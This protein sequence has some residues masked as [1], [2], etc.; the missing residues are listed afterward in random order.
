M[1]SR[2][3][4]LI[5]SLFPSASLASDLDVRSR[6]MV[7][8]GPYQAEILQVIDGDTV[9]ARV[10]IWPG[11]IAEY[12]VRV[13]GVDAPEISRPNCEAELEWGL[14]AKDQVERFYPVGKAIRLRNVQFDVWS[15]RVLADVERFRS[16]RYLSLKD[17]LLQRQ[18]AVEWVPSQGAVPWCLL[19]QAESQDDIEGQ[20]ISD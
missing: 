4:L 20:P 12:S 17:E 8:E 1:L 6:G 14:R 2:C 19:A 3:V 18:L 5:C 13:R 15:G 9:V 11:L 16:D 10:A 7:F